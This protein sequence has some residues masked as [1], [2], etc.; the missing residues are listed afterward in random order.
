MGRQGEIEGRENYL[1][2]EEEMTAS[3]RFGSYKI[4]NGCNGGVELALHRM[5]Q[6]NMDMGV[7]HET[8]SMG[9]IYMQKLSGYHVLAYNA[10][11]KHQGGVLLFYRNLSHFQVAVHYA[12]RWSSVSDDMVYV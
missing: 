4:C 8:N 12:I 3:I 9:V 6:V 10:P 2:K 1:I 5:V 7:F 11:S